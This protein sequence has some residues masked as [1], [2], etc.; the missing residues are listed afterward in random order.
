[1]S[2]KIR[3]NRIFALLGL[4]GLITLIVVNCMPACWDYIG[5]KILLAFGV[6]FLGFYLVITLFRFL[7][8]P[9]QRDILLAC[10]S[11]GLYVLMFVIAIPVL[12]STILI[13]TNTTVDELFLS[14]TENLRHCNSCGKT[15]LDKD[16]EPSHVLWDVYYHFVDPGNQHGTTIAGKIYTGILAIL[17]IFLFN[18]LLVTTIIGW[19]DQRKDKWQRGRIRYKSRHLPKGKFAVVIGANEIAASVI[20]NLLKPK[21]IEPTL[22]CLSDKENEYVILQTCSDVEKVRDVL[23]SHLSSRELEKVIIYNAQRDSE[24]EIA[25]LHL[26]HATEIYILG[27]NTTIDGGETYHDAMNMRCLNLIAEYLDNKGFSK[28]KNNAYKRKVC[29]VMFDYQTT[30]SVF[31][32]SDVSAKVK[33]T[34]IFVP[35]N[36]YESWARKVLVDCIAEDHGEVIEYTPLD[37]FEG[38]K[39][40]DDKRVHLIIVGMSK[41]GVAMGVQALLQLHFP[42]YVRDKA[43]KTRITFIDT[44]ADK[45]MAFFKGRYATL[46]E[47]ACHCYVD[48]ND[49]N[50]NKEEY[51]WQDPATKP[52][53]KWGHLSENGEN[54]LD[55]EIEFVKGELE[56][57]GVRRYLK[58]VAGNSL[59]SKLT[60]AICL[61]QTHQ[62]VAAALYMPIEV[63]ECKNLQ[64]ILVYQREADDIVSNLQNVKD[65]SIRYSK[66]RPFGM[67]YGEY[68]ENR[69]RYFK[70]QLVNM[71]Y[72]NMYDN[73]PWP[74]DV[75]NKEDVG[76][77]F[78]RKA[79]SELPISLKI[80]NK[81]FI[82]T[83]YQKMRS[84]IP[85][86]ACQ[87]IGG[88]HNIMYGNPVLCDN[89]NST[90]FLEMPKD[91]NKFKEEEFESK[92]TYRLAQTEHNRWNIE[93]LLM[94]FS[95]INKEQDERYRLLVKD[96]NSDAIEQL[97]QAHK[98][99]V[100]NIH[101]NICE[102]KHLKDI[103]KYGA[104]KY[105]VMLN[106]A[107]PYI[108][109]LVDGY[110]YPAHTYWVYKQDEQAFNQLCYDRS[111]THR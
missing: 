80:S 78:M 82:D 43:L 36:R 20:K 2:K 94:G 7:R 40:E 31:Q 25:Q 65:T 87:A 55:V 49:A 95:P 57:D 8:R 21:S 86:H 62:A 69:H 11:Y 46:F 71:A 67:L 37:G 111:T 63:Y 56:S 48:A 92:P 104:L 23:A 106:N 39:Y 41:M 93:K 110:M 88:Y 90:F 26:G 61:T 16:T 79:W 103:D 59:N 18:G 96:K 47:L 99:S 53:Y 34:L 81:F 35:F 32:F 101:P 84:M 107:I 24:R 66:L 22:D 100:A 3:Y 85:L 98:S 70:A 52:N 38:I 73:V 42:N 68:M 50:Q 54:F 44:N 14:D 102:F 109:L 9:I 97:K 33:D 15:Y 91:M 64:Q 74:I 4:L 5:I 105:D 30:Y 6:F 13:L 76:C 12:C 17:G 27:E 60:I 51:K 75:L 10:K 108:L 29:R 28:N 77:N 1:M 72:S 83:I 58:E 45:E 19:V 89:L